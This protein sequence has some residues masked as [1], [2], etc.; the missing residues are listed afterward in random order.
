MEP[1][2]ELHKKLFLFSLEVVLK[3]L[4]GS[5]ARR[6]EEK[7]RQSKENPEK[8]YLTRAN[9]NYRSLSTNHC[10]VDLGNVQKQPVISPQNFPFIWPS[11]HRR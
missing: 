7:L 5:R 9:R 11:P 4:Q 10:S 8:L 6:K 1:D 2:G 3:S